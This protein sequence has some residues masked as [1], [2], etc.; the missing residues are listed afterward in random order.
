MLH[1]RVLTALIAFCGLGCS[2]RRAPIP[3]AAAKTV[4]G[5]DSGT[6]VAL[7]QQFMQ[8]DL[9]S[10]HDSAWALLYGCLVA[11]VADYLEPSIGAH[12][13]GVAAQHDTVVVTAEYIVVGR[14]TSDDPD[15][16]SVPGKYWHFAPDVRTDT[17]VFPVI[18]DPAGRA[19][20]DC[21]PFPPIHVSVDSVPDA[22]AHMDDLSRTKWTAA[23]IAAE[24][25][26]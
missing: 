10:Q 8:A 5:V 16:A 22:L 15:R 11:P 9:H 18:R 2:H 17:L 7:V 25:L 26:R 3:L 20:I 1:P 12:V 13:I 23:L 19:A 6:A 14:L 4:V 21:G 24:R